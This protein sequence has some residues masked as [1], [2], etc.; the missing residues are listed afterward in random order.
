MKKLFIL[1]YF[2]DEQLP[3]HHFRSQRTNK[4][5]LWQKLSDLGSKYIQVAGG[6]GVNIKA[7][8]LNISFF[9][10]TFEHGFD[11]TNKLKLSIVFDFPLVDSVYSLQFRDEGIDVVKMIRRLIGDFLNELTNVFV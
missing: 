5:V 6:M 3:F 7:P 1:V 10:T 2:R 4:N 8:E 9:K 11:F